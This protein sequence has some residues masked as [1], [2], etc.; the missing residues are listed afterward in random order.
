MKKETKDIELG[1]RIKA[2]STRK[3]I[4]NEFSNERIDEALNNDELGFKVAVRRD[5]SPDKRL[6][7][8]DILSEFVFLDD[9]ETIINH[10]ARTSFEFEGLDNLDSEVS[11]GIVGMTMPDDAFIQ[12]HSL[13]YTHAR[14]LLYSKLSDSYLSDKII[15]PVIDS[16]T[17][18]N[19]FKEI[20][21]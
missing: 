5:I 2:I 6:V 8:I 20:E 11:E 7:N 3:L 4:L 21:E 16:A 18:L 12:I 1:Y 9:M 10:V 14:A 15:L 13:A 17:F 19:I